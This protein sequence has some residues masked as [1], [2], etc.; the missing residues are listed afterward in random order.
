[1]QRADSIAVV[2]TDEAASIGPDTPGRG[3]VDRG[4]GRPVPFQSA[5]VDP[6]SIDRSRRSRG[7]APLGA[8][9]SLGRPACPSDRARR[10]SAPS[11]RCRASP[12]APTSSCSV[13]PTSPSGSAMTLATWSPAAD[14]H[15]LVRRRARQRA[16]HARSRPSRR[17][18]RRR[19]RRPGAPARRPASGV[20]RA[21]RAAAA[22][23]RG[24][25]PATGRHRRPRRALPRLAGRIPA[26]GA[27]RGG[28]APPRGAGTRTRGRRG[29][30]SRRIVLGA[31]IRELS[32]RACCCAIRRGRISC[33]RAV[34]ARLWRADDPPGSGQ[35]RGHRVQ[36]VVADR[37]TAGTAAP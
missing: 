22:V 2:G 17:P 16:H 32:A 29:G 6:A 30:R 34:S 35:W 11:A 27:R 12:P 13:S 19:R 15:L 24:T 36:F 14:G 7:R 3:I 31:G 9:S 26:G 20:G 28:G 33:R 8:R 10:R 1:M 18:H 25:T 4:D 37:A 5:L 23:R 21:A